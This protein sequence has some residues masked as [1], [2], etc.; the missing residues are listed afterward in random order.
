[1]AIEYPGYS[2]YYQEKSAQTIEEDALVVFDYFVKE[3]GVNEKDIIICGRSIGSGPAVYLAANRDPGAF[4]LISPFKSIRETANSILGFLKFIVAD[5]FRNIDIISKATCPLLLIHGQKDNLI[6]FEHSIELS[7]KTGGPYEL[8]LPEEMNHN[9]FNLYDDFQEP[10]TNFLKRHNL[11]SFNSNN[12][13][14]LR[15]EMFEIPEYILDPENLKK[16]DVMS[17]MIRKVLKI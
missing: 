2:I 11:L 15:I 10:I 16:K 6:P 5:R 3:I 4:I 9:E 12:K 14:D 7:Q 13:I 1:V 17:K 8:I